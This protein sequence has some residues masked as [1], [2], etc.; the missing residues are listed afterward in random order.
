[1]NHEPDKNWTVDEVQET[2]E[3]KLDEKED[4]GENESNQNNELEQ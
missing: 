4:A 3:T 1:M 2:N